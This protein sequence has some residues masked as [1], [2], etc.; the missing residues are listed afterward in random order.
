[1]EINRIFT[2]RKDRQE[3]NVWEETFYYSDSFCW[4]KN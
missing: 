1:M 3:Y 4:F 2:L